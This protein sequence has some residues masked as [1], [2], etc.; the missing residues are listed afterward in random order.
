MEG[1]GEEGGAAAPAGL[2][3]LALVLRPRGARSGEGTASVEGGEDAGRGLGHG[4]VH[5][6]DDDEGGI[7][8]EAAIGEAG[9]RI[10]G[11][12]ENFGPD[13]GAGPEPYKAMGGGVDDGLHRRPR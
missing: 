2:A 8:E 10:E 5:R 13:E 6:V 4:D 9:L 7:G 11:G 3:G 1:V 12:A